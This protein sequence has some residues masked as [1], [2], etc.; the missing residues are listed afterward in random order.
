MCARLAHR[1]DI[2]A[3]GP[4]SDFRSVA[5]PRHSV[6]AQTILDLPINDQTTN[7][8]STSRIMKIPSYP[9]PI[10]GHKQADDYIAL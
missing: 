9:Q 2:S 6:A 10:Q 7:L 1:K 4:H 5:F 3:H 8:V